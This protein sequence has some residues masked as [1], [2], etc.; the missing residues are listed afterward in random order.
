MHHSGGA[1]AETLYIYANPLQQAHQILTAECKTCIV[2]LGLGYIE[3]AWALS[4]L[5]NGLKPS[6]E[7]TF[8][9]FEIVEEL[10]TRFLKWLHSD[11]E[12][13]YDLIV[14]KMTTQF[15]SHVIKSTLKQ[16]L[17]SGSSIEKDFSESYLLNTKWNVI[18][19]DA[20]S[21]KTNQ[22]LWQG[23]FLDLFLKDQTAEDCILTTYACT[24]V[25]RKTLIENNFTFI[26]RVGFG[27]KRDSSLALRGK[28]KVEFVPMEYDQT[29]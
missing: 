7:I 20:F 19:Y 1:A 22:K 15:S 28:F 8:H 26:K 4:L 2:G 5:K 6:S 11:A 17:L 21:Q 29:F 10:R 13:L 25:L 3:V 16:G 14:K 24:G 12:S 9:T 27:G 18:C 23:E